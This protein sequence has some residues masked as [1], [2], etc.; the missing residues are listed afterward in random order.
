[1][2]FR[3]KSLPHLCMNKYCPCH[4]NLISYFYFIALLDTTMH[5]LQCV[6]FTFS[7]QHITK[8]A[9]KLKHTLESSNTGE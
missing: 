5:V 3:L 6:K 1:M 4:F 7:N 2:Y 9:A 8:E